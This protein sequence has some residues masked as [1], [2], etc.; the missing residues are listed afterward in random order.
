MRVCGRFT[1]SSRKGAA[2]AA[3]DESVGQQMCVAL[4]IKP[5]M[6]SWHYCGKL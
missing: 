3:T 1:Y 6:A 2:L 5:G 4:L